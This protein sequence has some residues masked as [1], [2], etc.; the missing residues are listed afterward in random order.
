[1]NN[2]YVHQ[3]YPSVRYHRSGVTTVVYDANE[4]YELM[5]DP[6]WATTPAAFKEEPKE[7]PKEANGI[8]DSLKSDKRRGRR[9][10]RN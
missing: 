6:D 5:Q 9:T 3:P 4:H 10:T 1:M 8:P 7:E 2:K